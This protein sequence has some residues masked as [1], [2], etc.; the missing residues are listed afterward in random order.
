MYS[1]KPHINEYLQYYFSNK[2]LDE[3][4]LSTA[5]KV[6][7]QS[8]AGIFIPIYL[9][10][11][12]FE[13]PL[14]AAYYGLHYLIVALLYPVGMNLNARIGVKKT[15][16]LGII[17]M[18]GFYF[19][20]QYM[21]A[22]WSFIASAS[23]WGAS[24]AL[25]FSARQMEFAK[26]ADSGKEGVEYSVIRVVSILSGAVGP[27]LGAFIISTYSFSLLLWVVA[28][29]LLLAPLP[30]FWTKDVKYKKPDISWENVRQSGTWSMAFANQV[31]AIVGLSI[32]VL[33]PIFIYQTLN[34]VLSLGIIVSATA[35]IVVVVNLLLGRIADTR[36]KMLLKIGAI[37]HSATWIS[38]L[39]F[40]SPVGVFA[41][42]FLSSATHSATIIPFVK[43]L[44]VKAKKAKDLASYFVFREL[45][46][47]S[48]RLALLGVLFFVPDL[49]VIF[50]GMALFSL[51]FVF[52][53]RG[54]EE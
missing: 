11:V 40:L 41:S 15:M 3:I 4:Y 12:G 46:L 24:T 42:N 23:L 49:N 52:I 14:I 45:S 10:T 17:A 18:V 36:P 9:L 7:A 33:W 28:G 37:S 34:E 25:Y 43:I 16:S 48:G 1:V 50:Y 8:M 53:G 22:L 27:V 13:L 39:F 38:R 47:F 29:L 20:L 19:A 21:P 5:I 32:A 6:F 2:E 26:I 31:D 44:Y 51:C 30:L 35:A 54:Y